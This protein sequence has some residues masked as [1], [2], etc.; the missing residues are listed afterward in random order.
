MTPEDMLKIKSDIEDALDTLGYVIHYFKGSGLSA[1][2]D[3]MES[4]KR[5]KQSLDVIEKEGAK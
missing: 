5:L 3:I 2:E 4:I 1:G